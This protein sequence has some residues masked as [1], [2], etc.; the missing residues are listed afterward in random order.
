M[1]ALFSIFSKLGG[2]LTG[3]VGFKVFEV[4][5]R[6]AFVGILVTMYLAL[7]VAFMGTI[8]GVY[9]FSPVAPSGN[10]AAGLALL[11]G[12]VGQCMSAIGAAHVVCHV[13]LMK[14][15]I[16]KLTSKAA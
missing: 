9:T 4:T 14:S 11:P 10:V 16:I 8:M 7:Y 6:Y 3:A 12:N 2:W 13:V 15:K 5:N 1:N